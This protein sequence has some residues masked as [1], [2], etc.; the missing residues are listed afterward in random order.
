MSV[1]MIMDWNHNETTPQRNTTRAVPASGFPG[2]SQMGAGLAQPVFRLTQYYADL[3]DATV[4]DQRDSRPAIR[5][6]LAVQFGVN[7]ST[8]G[9][10]TKM[11]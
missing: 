7:N 9:F 2:K 6:R 1:R 5:Q 11:S 4:I 3:V 10:S 8:C